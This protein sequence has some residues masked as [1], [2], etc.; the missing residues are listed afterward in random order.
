[1]NLFIKGSSYI[2]YLIS[3]PS[4]HQISQIG[5][6]PQVQEYWLGPQ[7]VLVTCFAILAVSNLPQTFKALH[8]I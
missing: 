6:I 1:M 7:T 5:R 4:H 2:R 8:G 3:E